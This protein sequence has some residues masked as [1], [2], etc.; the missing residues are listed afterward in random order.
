MSTN[1]AALIQAKAKGKKGAWL[2]PL[3]CHSKSAM[4][5]FL[6]LDDIDRR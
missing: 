3:Q 5:P 4:K 1:F 6:H 2:I